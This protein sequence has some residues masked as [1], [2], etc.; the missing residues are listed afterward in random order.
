M[1]TLPLYGWGG[2]L[3]I[4][5]S[6]VAMFRRIEPFWSFH[7]PIAWTGYILAADAWVWKRRGES[8]IRNKPAELLFLAFLSIPLWVIFELYNKYS[9]RNWYY[10]GLPDVMAVRYLGYAWSF[11]TIW[12][13]IFETGD[14][15]SSLRD[16]RA[17]PYR[18]T[19]SKRHEPGRAGWCAVALGAALLAWPIAFPSVYL[20]APVFLGFTLLLDPLNAHAGHESILGDLREGHRGRL[21]NLLVAGLCCGVLWEFWN[22]WAHAKWIYN[23]PIL[24]DVK[25]FEMPALGFTGFP[26]FAVECFAMYVA[27]R[28]WL[29]RVAPH[30][31]AL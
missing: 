19:P 20:A 15:V 26:P 18:A 9:L 8:W 12:P 6:E 27:A 30:P 14:L 23:V 4:A 2:L 1:R 28:R 3:L 10:V 7:T 13:A 31:I 5:I 22:Y 24:A 11:A 16:R 29:W 25:L 17:P 21:V